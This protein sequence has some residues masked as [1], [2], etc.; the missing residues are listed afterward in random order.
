M[1]ID[2]LQCNA[3]DMVQSIDKPDYAELER[4]EKLRGFAILDT[5]QEHEFDA[6][7]MLTQRVLDVPISLVDDRR[8]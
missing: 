5:P 8:Q 7:V 6:I 4:V 1:E 2:L 3:S